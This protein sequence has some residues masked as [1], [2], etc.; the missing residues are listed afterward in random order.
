MQTLHSLVL[1]LALGLTVV[2]PASALSQTP[3]QALQAEGRVDAIVA[4]TTGVEAGLGLS[5]P[6]GIYMRTGLVAG[7]G[8]GRH[9]VEGRTDLISR[10]SLDPFR[11]SRWAP[12]AGAGVSGRYRAK[13]DGGSHAYL[14]IFLGVEGPLSPGA[15]SGIVPAFELGLGGGARLAV[16]LRRG[17][18][19]RR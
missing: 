10:F 9:G 7:I 6:S 3:E 14:M 1:R 19:A 15:T 8:A 12:Y 2:V 16:I 17:I 13:L 18:N 4:R 11:Q 5:A